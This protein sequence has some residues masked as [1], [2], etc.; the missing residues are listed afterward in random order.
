MYYLHLSEPHI[1]KASAR[2]RGD[3]QGP[4]ASVSEAKG[5]FVKLTMWFPEAMQ[6]AAYRIVKR[7]KPAEVTERSSGLSAC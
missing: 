3:F 1:R 2:P 5:F 4:F 6:G 7:D